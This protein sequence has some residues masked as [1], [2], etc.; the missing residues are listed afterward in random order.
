MN[1][2]RTQ[3]AFDIFYTKFKATEAYDYIIKV[4]ESCKTVQQLG[5]AYRWGV[6]TMEGVHAKMYLYSRSRYGYFSSKGIDL[7]EYFWDRIRAMEDQIEL[8]YHNLRRE[9]P[10]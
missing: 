8:K 1:R 10:E 5:V 7:E 3:E 2:K 9:I 6:E 4:M